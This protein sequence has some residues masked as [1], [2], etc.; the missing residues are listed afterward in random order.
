M[1]GTHLTRSGRGVALAERWDGVR[2]R[3]LRPANAG[4][5]RATI[6]NGVACWGSFA[7]MT[8]GET[9]D[10][11]GT[12]RTFAEMVNG[13]GWRIVPTPTGPGTSML[14]GVGCRSSSSCFAV[15]S[16]DAGPLV[17]RWNGGTWSRQ[18]VPVPSGAQFTGLGGIA[19]TPSSCLAVG[20]YVDSS[21]TD[22]PLSLRWRDGHW[23]VLPSVAPDGASYAFLSG[24]TCMPGGSCV[25]VGGSSEGTLVERLTASRWRV[26]PSPSPTGAQFSG[27][28]AVS[29]AR[30]DRCSAVGAYLNANG[31]FLSLAAQW[32]GARWRLAATHVPD[33][34]TGNYFAGVACLRASSCF[35]VGQAGGTGTPTVLVNHWDGTRWQPGHAPS[36]R[37]P[38][39][40]QLNS[41]SCAAPS[42]C[43]AVGTAGPTGGRL[44]TVAE[45]WDRRRWRLQ[46]TP[47]PAGSNLNGVSCPNARWCMAVGQSAAGTMAQ[48]WAGTR[49]RIVKIPTPT[50][51]AGL[52]GVKCLS[53]SFCMAV[54]GYPTASG[55]QVPFAER[56]NGH[57]W[58]IL[59]VPPADGAVQTF[60]GGI[61]CLSPAWC[62]TTGEQ[63]FASGLATPIADHWNGHRWAVQPTPHPARKDFSNLPSIS[64]TAPTRCIA[65]GGTSD[66]GGQTENGAIAERW[67]GTAW[68]LIAV[69]NPGGGL[70]GVSCPSPGVCTA[71]G[72]YVTNAG[73]RLFA[74]R[75]ENGSWTGQRTP[76]LPQVFQ[77]S[78]PSVSCATALTCMAAGGYE[79]DG[80]A[81]SL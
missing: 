8:V 34:D 78:Q 26:E 9:I 4:F 47:S 60:L 36:P 32:N 10:A 49:W 5:A 30:V 67:N 19:C 45:R 46:E 76:L 75:L 63:H 53:T 24:A 56:W 51:G 38:E 35:A 70:Y 66:D 64:C 50:P 23:R 77:M 72:S 6:L 48:E 29:C 16:T 57:T 52:A 79:P 42:V 44:S 33:G 22:L 81:R 61:D 1:V 2:W 11:R 58:H 43:T 27:L 74:D 71:T 69:P 3:I 55:G 37:G 39:E 28:F 80:P 21:G 18:A 17:E 73:G 62:T 13:A 12:V 25:A 68:R 59:P 20:D 31:D 54:G 14:V 40:T 15:G 7:C 41:V 65:V